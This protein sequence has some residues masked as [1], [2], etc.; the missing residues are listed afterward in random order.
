MD[1]EPEEPPSDHV[2]DVGTGERLVTVMFADVRGYTAMSGER[3][4]RDMA[5]RIASLQRWATREV[6]RHGGMVDRF[7]GDAVMATFNFSGARIDHAEHAMEA[8]IALQDKAA[9][10][11]LGLGVGLAAGPAIVGALALGGN[12]SVIGETTNLAARLQAQALA[13]E[14]LLS[15]GAFRRLTAWLDAKGLSL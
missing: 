11:D 7:A 8:A 15:A 12:V 9:L 4:P 3:A 1:L 14:V 6:D 10:M 13:G 5:E 2:V